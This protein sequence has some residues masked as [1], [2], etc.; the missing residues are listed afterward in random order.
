MTLVHQ[1][2]AD[3]HTK[4]YDGIAN[5]IKKASSRLRKR[6]LRVP[7][8]QTRFV[9]FMSRGSLSKRTL[10]K[11]ALYPSTVQDLE[12]DEISL[13]VPA[14]FR[15][16]IAEFKAKGC[17][18]EISPSGVCNYFPGNRGSEVHYFV[19]TVSLYRSNL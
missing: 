18:I 9:V 17:L 3:K 2:D 1:V 14:V 5:D 11:A 15:E 13:E 7:L 8:A 6:L 19:Y 16:V 10:A 12:V 4:I